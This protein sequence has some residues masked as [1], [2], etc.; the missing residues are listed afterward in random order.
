[1]VAAS[2]AHSWWDPIHRRTSTSSVMVPFLFRV[3]STLWTGIGWGRGVVSRWCL[4]TKYPF[5]NIP[6]ALESRRADVVMG[7]R[8]ETSWMVMVRLREH[9][10]FLDRT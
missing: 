7:Q 10:D 3:P 6:V 8:E 5:T 1:M 4:W 2:W 9:G